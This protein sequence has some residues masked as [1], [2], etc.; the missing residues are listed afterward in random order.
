MHPTPPEP[1]NAAQQRPAKPRC[2]ICSARL[3]ER[4]GSSCR[5]LGEVIIHR[6]RTEPVT[7]VQPSDLKV[8]G[9]G[10]PA[11]LVDAL[12]THGGHDTTCRR[13]TWVTATTCPTTLYRISTP[14]F[15]YAPT[16]TA[17]WADETVSPHGIHHP[18][19][20][21]AFRAYGGFT[22]WDDAAAFLDDLRADQHPIG[23]FVVPNPTGY[24]MPR[25]GDA[26]ITIDT[27]QE[28]TGDE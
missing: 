1:G 6:G 21:S 17:C 23:V 12:G 3:G 10:C 7:D 2:H 4:H 13:A 11:V 19:H 26:P 22:T 24:Q 5:I 25:P 28:R 8:A 18:T 14:G 27:V 9:C 15:T 16:W 20:A